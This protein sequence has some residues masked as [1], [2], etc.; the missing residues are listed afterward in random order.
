[1]GRLPTQ[2]FLELLSRNSILL[3]MNYLALPFLCLMVASSLA[4]GQIQ[5]SKSWSR[6]LALCCGTVTS[7]CAT[8]CAGKSC[9]IQCSGRCGILNTLCGPYKCSAVTNACTSSSANT[10]AA[11]TTAAATTAAPTT[12]GA[13]TA[14]ATTAAATTAAACLPTG[15]YCSVNGVYS[16]LKCCTGSECYPDATNFQLGVCTA[17]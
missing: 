16:A 10:A 8:G 6:Q 17:V 9:D 4:G 2:F 11:A 3:T 1:M 15:G 5:V 12:A 13:T 7:K 14:A